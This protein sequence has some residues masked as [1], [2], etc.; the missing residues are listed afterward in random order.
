VRSGFPDF[1]CSR[2]E[3]VGFYALFIECNQGEERILDKSVAESSL[4]SVVLQVRL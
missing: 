3:D 4:G 2:Y 1:D